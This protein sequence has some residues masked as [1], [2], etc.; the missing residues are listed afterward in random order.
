MA[1]ETSGVEKADG[2]ET[3]QEEVKAPAE[4]RIKSGIQAGSTGKEEPLGTSGTGVKFSPRGDADKSKVGVKFSAKVRSEPTVVGVKFEEKSKERAANAQVKF[5]KKTDKDK[6]TEVIEKPSSLKF[7]SKFDRKEGGKG[8]KDD[9][10]PAKFIRKESSEES[11]GSGERKKTAPKDVNGGRVEGK[12]VFLMKK[13]PRQPQDTKFRRKGSPELSGEGGVAELKE[14]DEIEVLFRKTEKPG[15]APEDRVE[16][17]E[18]ERD[19]PTGKKATFLK[20][21]GRGTER[22]KKLEKE[23]KKAAF[24]VKRPTERSAIIPSVEKK[25]QRTAFRP[26]KTV[27]ARETVHSADRKTEKRKDT[28]F[29]KTKTKDDATTGR[30]KEAL[31]RRMLSS[32][33]LTGAAISA[34]TMIALV[35]MTNFQG[36]TRDSDV[37]RMCLLPQ[38]FILYFVL[39]C[40]T[41]G[42]GVIMIAAGLLHRIRSKE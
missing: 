27:N 1:E 24:N 29:R 25:T 37:L 39:I 40:I 28:G 7:V 2:M 4:F 22:P 31:M 16:T 8:P 20:K 38:L 18:R 9:V 10:K 17:V 19:A 41:Y 11:I 36:E 14:R 35:L 15:A 12:K 23:G 21:K 6:P 33:I 3:P 42:I 34:L 30:M 26:A 32:K 5:S 13:P